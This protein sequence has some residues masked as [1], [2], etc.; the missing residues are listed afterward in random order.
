MDDLNP[1]ILDAAH[2]LGDAPLD[3]ASLVEHIHPLFSRV[4]ARNQQRD[5]IYLA[6]HSL[7]RPPDLV[8]TE[9]AR[10]LDAWYTDLDEAWELWIDARDRYRR[11][12]ARLLSWPQWDAVVP[13]TSAGQGLRAVL[14]AMPASAPGRALNI[15]STR[16]E[17]DS[18]DFILKAYAHKGLARVR[19]VEP[20]RHDLIETDDLLDAIDETTDLV[21]VSMVCFVTA[22]IIDDIERVIEHARRCGALV[23]L[24]A[25]H[26]FGVLPIDFGRLDPDFVIAGNYKYT[27]GGP[28]ACFLAVNPAHLSPAGGVPDPG[29]LMPIDTGW[30]AKQDP[31]AYRRTDRPQYAPG[32]DAW[33]ESTPPVFTYFQALPGLELTL[34]L[35]VGR[36]RD[37]SLSQQALL[38]EHLKAN[39]VTPSQ[40]EQHGAYVLVEV[41]DGH[42]VARQ[43]KALGVNA[44]ARPCPRTHAWVV[45]L[46][47]DLLNTERELIEAARRIGHVIGDGEGEFVGEDQSL[48]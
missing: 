25:Y 4:L 35:G 43:L 12:V 18:I 20:D 39:G 37:Y 11:R 41:D 34:A 40:P 26:A 7:G 22:Q 33:L 46:C 13:K 17:F 28:G 47:P 38:I 1:T 16:A 14:N 3:E 44:D 32:G 23:V 8:A 36:L 30:F 27:R 45:R 9:I 15:V 10:A 42:D 6:N 2:K 21:V 48:S 19:W 24:D 29:S 31:F 5:E